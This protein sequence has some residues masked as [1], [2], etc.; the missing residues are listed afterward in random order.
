MSY[1]AS[2]EVF[3]SIIFPHLNYCCIIWSNIKNK[4][5]I[6]K[7]YRLQKR[8]ART[9]LNEKDRYTPTSVLFRELR[10]MSLPDYYIFR[11]LILIFKILHILTPDYL[12]VFKYVYQVSRRSTRLSTSNSLYYQGHGRNILRGLSMCLLLFYGMNY[13]SLLEIVQL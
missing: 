7:L 2:F 6:D 3:N 5:N 8:S 11:K 13:Q 12:N 10:W 1:E 9:I 4:G